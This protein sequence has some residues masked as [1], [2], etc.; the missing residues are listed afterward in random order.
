MSL[1]LDVVFD[2][3]INVHWQSQVPLFVLFENSGPFPPGSFTL[4]IDVVEFHTPTNR[5][6]KIHVSE[7]GKTWTT[8]NM[9][10]DNGPFP[11]YAYGNGAWIFAYN[12]SNGWI[13]G[14][15]GG[16]GGVGPWGYTLFGVDYGQS[17]IVMSTDGF[18]WTKRV[19]SAR[20]FPPYHDDNGSL[21]G[22]NDEP[23]LDLSYT[24]NIFHY[25]KLVT[26]IRH[27]P[28]YTTVS[29]QSPFKSIVVPD[30]PP[31]PGKITDV[32]TQDPFLNDGLHPGF[33]Y[34]EDHTATWHHT[35]T[36]PPTTGIYEADVELSFA[37]PGT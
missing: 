27:A 33:W 17:T 36:L 28:V 37:T 9:P 14:R 20:S 18:T 15:D 19:G 22:P 4:P 2:T 35:V 30:N 13:Y 29:I 1:S 3:V 21:V 7:D 8:I 32:T 11:T 34:S 5:V 10:G 23:I 26:P 31:Y 16:G 6:N 12:Q 25:R 24:P